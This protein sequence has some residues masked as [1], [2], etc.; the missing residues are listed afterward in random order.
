M[1]RCIFVGIPMMGAC[2]PQIGIA[3]QLVKKG[4]EVIFVN[5]E[6][7]KNRVESIGALLVTY[8]KYKNEKFEKCEKY[9]YEQAFLAADKILKEGDILFYDSWFFCG[10]I[11][12]K[13]H[14]VKSIRLSSMFAMNEKVIKEFWDSNLMWGFYKLPVYRSLMTRRFARTIPIKN[15]Y[16]YWKEIVDATPLM[17]IV[18]TEESFQVH[19]NDFGERYNFVGPIIYERNDKSNIPYSEMKKIIFVAIGS[20]S[21]DKK[22]IET[23]ISCFKN[24]DVSVIISMGNSKLKNLKNLPDNIYLYNSVPQLEVLSHADFFISHGG[25][26]SVNEALYYGVP[27]IICPQFADHMVIGEQVEQMRLGIVLAEK[28]FT[29]NN[30][31]KAICLLEKHRENNKS[32]M[33][34]V[35]SICGLEKSIELIENVIAHNKEA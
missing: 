17:D 34:R 33:A 11:L 18:F 8:S 15:K 4:Y 16:N 1:S 26:N 9:L 13:K 6:L 23:C 25:M 30:I 20:I 29:S 7:I 22:I 19:R 28:D 35:Q 3:E 31:N 10:D 12:A 27:M 2:L 14:K 21:N 32:M 5:S 24:Q